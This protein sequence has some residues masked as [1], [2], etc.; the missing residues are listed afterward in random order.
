MAAKREGLAQEEESP[1]ALPAT[2]LGC[3]P[4]RRGASCSRG[5]VWAGSFSAARYC[6][7][8]VLVVLGLLFG[9]SSP[10]NHFLR[11]P[12]LRLPLQRFS[13]SLTFRRCNARI[14]AP[15]HP[16]SIHPV[17]S[18]FTYNLELTTLSPAPL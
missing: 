6:P 12:S 3:A 2:A 17:L 18:R 11:A 13:F 10:E 4:V 9:C 7:K 5:R 8:V 15:L 16:H 14:E 1:L